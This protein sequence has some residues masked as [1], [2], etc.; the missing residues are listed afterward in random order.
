VRHRKRCPTHPAEVNDITA[1]LARYRWIRLSIAVAIGTALLAAGCASSPP[2][3]VENLC[4]IFYEKDGFFDNWHKFARRTQKKYGV[5]I[6]TLMATIYQE[7][8]F[9]PKAKPPRTRL[10]WVIPWRRP[11][12]AYGFAQALDST[13]NEYMTKTNRHGADRDKFKYAIDFIG[14]YFYGT[15]RRHGVALNDTYHL[16]LAY[17]E[18]NGGFGRRTYEKKPWLKAVAR[19]VDR[20]AKHYAR[21]YQGCWKRL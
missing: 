16:Y 13:W 21:Q 11:T 2:S 12:S 14:W 6:P 20:R 10:L 4:T 5:P 9:Q 7:S 15:H 19:K 3:Q 8:R 17:H 18:G 1:F